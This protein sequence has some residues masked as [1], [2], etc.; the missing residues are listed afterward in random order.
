MRKLFGTDGIRG[1]ANRYPMDAYTA[2]K[3]GAAVGHYFRQLHRAPKVLIGRD[4]R[5]SGFMLQNAIAAG[6]CAVGC[7]AVEL[8][9]VS[10]PG[11]AYLTH[12][13]GADAG[14][15]I[16][17]SHNPY[18]DNGIKIF[19]N[20]GF[21]LPDANE[22]EIEDLILNTN[23]DDLHV[24]PEEIGMTS[25]R[26]EAVRWYSE[27]LSNS[28]GKRTFDGMKIV[29]DCAHGAATNIAPP[30][31]RSLRAKVT[32]IGNDPDGRNINDGIGSLYPEQLQE[33][34]RKTGADFGVAFDGDAD[35]A[36]FV[37]A[38]GLVVDGDCIMAICAKKLNDDGH[39]MH[40]TLVATVM[41]N[42]G[43]HRA[44]EAE[45]IKVITTAVGD[46]YVVE[47]MRSHGYNFGGEQSGHLI[48]LDYSTTGDGILTALQV[49]TI[50]Y[51]SGRPLHELTQLMT[52]YPQVL[53]NLKVKEKRP[54]DTLP[55]VSGLIR[56]IEE[57]LG[58]E[59]RVLVRYSGTE[60]LAR[61]MVE[62]LDQQE[63]DGYA[64]E[65]LAA[66][67]KELNQT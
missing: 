66:I 16:S 47:E 1:Q 40:K 13:K 18:I 62:G 35:R 23:S 3:V 27:I 19:S 9:V 36:I 49:L 14:I 45:G 25:S 6:L 64:S 50:L 38:N 21:K 30:I 56:Q 52:R 48:F 22:L 53:L 12:H 51:D 11:V 67:D 39:L 2:Y 26:P 63:I 60:N 46:R 33:T 7:E 44:M 57:K 42:I 37:D 20:D 61:V 59:G 34:V 8:G 28:V 10:T 43:L 55:S 32:T 15:M 31:F 4:T 17:A 29:L 65:I 54:I 58:K 5:L 41:S 24:A